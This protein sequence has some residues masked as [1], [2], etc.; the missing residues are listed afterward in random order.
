MNNPYK[1]ERQWPIE[2]EVKKLLD[3]KHLQR[4]FVFFSDVHEGG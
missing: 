1:H 3:L 2:D 4:L